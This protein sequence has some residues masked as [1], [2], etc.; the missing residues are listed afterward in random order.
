MLPAA[1]AWTSSDNNAV[2]YVLP[3]LWMTSCFPVWRWQCLRERRSSGQNFQRIRQGAPHRLT[4]SSHTM[5]ANGSPAAARRNVM[6]AIASFLQRAAMLA[7]RHAVPA[8][9]IP[10]VCPSVC[11]SVTRR[12]CVKTTARSTVLLALSDSKM[13]LVL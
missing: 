10:S 5:A 13:C 1:M 4:L 9:A 7:L 12:Y 2:R 6:S 11:P 8:T 3:V